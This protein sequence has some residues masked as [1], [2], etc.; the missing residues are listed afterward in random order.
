MTRT[1]T[2]VAVSPVDAPLVE[3]W[4]VEFV[5]DECQFHLRRRDGEPR[6]GDP[7]ALVEPRDQR[8]Q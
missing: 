7:A 6:R 8:R 2:E 4:L 3:R 5:R 1:F